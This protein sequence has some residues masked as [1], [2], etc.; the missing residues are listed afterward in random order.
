MDSFMRLLKNDLYKCF[1]KKTFILLV[2]LMVCGIAVSGV[3]N[4]KLFN[5]E[6]WQEMLLAQNYEMTKYVENTEGINER[7]RK[8]Y[9]TKIAENNYSIENSIKPSNFLNDVMKMFSVDTILELVFIMLFGSFV[10]EEYTSKAFNN[11]LRSPNKK[12]SI[13][14]SQFITGIVLIVALATVLLLTALA[15]AGIKN[16]FSEIFAPAVYSKNGVFIETT[17]FMRIIRNLLMY[18]P[19]YVLNLSIVFMIAHVTRNPI[20]TAALPLFLALSGTILSDSL[21]KFKLGV[22]W[23]YVHTNLNQYFEQSQ[24][25]SYMSIGKSLMVVALYVFAGYVIA[26]LTTRKK[27]LYC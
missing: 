18:L 13:F 7:I 5:E 2:F 9:D 4:Y 6:N 25:Y 27:A 12:S 3:T 22:L 10:A 16:G 8:Y 19:Q 17:I 20:A 26:Y 14:L 24:Y 11:T 15:V 21:T 23:P 1:K